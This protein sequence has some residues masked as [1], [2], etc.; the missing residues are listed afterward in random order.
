MAILAEAVMPEEVRIPERTLLQGT[1]LD[2]L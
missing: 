1:R 2:L